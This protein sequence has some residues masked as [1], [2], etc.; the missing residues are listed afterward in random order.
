M[1][2]MIVLKLCK[3]TGFLWI[4]QR[5]CRTHYGL[6]CMPARTLHRTLEII[7]IIIVLFSYSVAF[8]NAKNLTFTLMWIARNRKE[9]W[10]F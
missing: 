10:E 8:K 2:W 4:V 6:S 5:V 1:I 9:D 3:T 7:I